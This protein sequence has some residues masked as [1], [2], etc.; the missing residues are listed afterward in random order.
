LVS[1][2]DAVS[3]LIPATPPI[4]SFTDQ[5]TRTPPVFYRINVEPQD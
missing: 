5:V 4:N 2:F 3:G 1:G